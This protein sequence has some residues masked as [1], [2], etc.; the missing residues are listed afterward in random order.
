MNVDAKT[1]ITNLSSWFG[2]T[3]PTNDS[4]I[5]HGYLESPRNVPG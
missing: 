1:E 3:Y 5:Q 4:I 2:K